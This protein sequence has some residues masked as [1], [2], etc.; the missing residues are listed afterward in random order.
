MTWSQLRSSLSSAWVRQI[1]TALFRARSRN[2]QLRLAE[3]LSLGDKRFVALLECSDRR[4]LIGGTSQ[5]IRLLTEIRGP[6]RAS[7]LFVRPIRQHERMQ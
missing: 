7:H 3:T 1:L 2:R 4:F 5:S 6:N